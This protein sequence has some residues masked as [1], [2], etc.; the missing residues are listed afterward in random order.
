MRFL[1]PSDRARTLGRR[2]FGLMSSA[3]SPPGFAR[4][5]LRI[6]AAAPDSL[7][8]RND[9]SNSPGARN[10]GLCE[11]CGD[12]CVARRSA[13]RAG[14]APPGVPIAPRLVHAAGHRRRCGVDS[15]GVDKI[16]QVRQH[17]AAAEIGGGGA[18]ARDRRL[19]DADDGGRAAGRAQAGA[20]G[21]DG[22]AVEDAASQSGLLR[23]LRSSQRR[24]KRCA[25]LSPGRHPR[26]RG[27]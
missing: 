19:A 18:V 1:S 9:C 25:R 24:R 22:A 21:G 17:L 20:V 16:V 7:G 2:D 5:V 13:T 27:A 3:D 12:T 26:G 23:R 4:E 14:E 10:A 6:A 15:V 8:K 11:R